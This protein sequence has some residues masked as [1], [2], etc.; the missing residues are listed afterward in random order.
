MVW[1]LR[2]HPSIPHPLTGS[3]SAVEFSECWCRCRPA[4][5]ES[6][7]PIFKNLMNSSK[8]IVDVPKSEGISQSEVVR[9][10]SSLVQECKMT[11]EFPVVVFETGSGMR[12]STN[13]NEVI[14]NR[15]IEILGGEF[16]SKDPVHPNDHVNCSQSSNDTFP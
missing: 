9:K 13:S 1:Q 6:I 14:S 10:S 5:G 16:G 15:A 2:V 4:P 12:F 11:E 8:P 7:G 3:S